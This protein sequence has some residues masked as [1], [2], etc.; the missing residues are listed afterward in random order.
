[1]SSNIPG[2]PGSY[3]QPWARLLHN[4]IESD[5]L[6]RR[7]T[8]RYTR[9]MA[10]PSGCYKVAITGTMYG[11]EIWATGFWVQGGVPA[12][13]SDA[14]DTA[15]AWVEA[16][17]STG[18]VGA[19]NAAAQTLQALAASDTTATLLTVYCYPTGGP[20]AS[21]QGAAVIAANGS[22]NATQNTPNQTCAVVSLRTA[23][24]GRSHRGRMYWPA[25]SP[26]GTSHGQ[27]P[28]STTQ[29]LAASWGTCF[30]GW[31]ADGTKG[32]PAVMSQTLSALTPISRIVMDT[33][34]DIQRRRANRE[35]VIA[36]SSSPVTPP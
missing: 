7:R 30:G 18:T 12:N 13:A 8:Q 1:V 4:M 17:F 19:T 34:L 16:L 15:A 20:H 29:T 25:T 31:A 14:G 32:V 33:R 6:L 23:L 36:T 2:V 10:I 22:G 3:P 28:G 11:G 5:W 24:T 35:A 9:G 27:L 21:Y 26:D